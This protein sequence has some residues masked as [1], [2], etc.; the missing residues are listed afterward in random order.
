MNQFG[1]Q[2]IY[3]YS[4]MSQGNSDIFFFYKIGA[5][6]DTTGLVWGLVSEGVGRMWGKGVGG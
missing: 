6:E 1:L 2:Y 3:I 4:E 5:Q